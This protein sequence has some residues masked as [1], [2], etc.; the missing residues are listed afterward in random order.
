MLDDEDAPIHPLFAGAPSST[1]F[2]KLR[3]RIVRAVRV[4]LEWPVH[5]QRLFWA[6]FFAT[7]GLIQY[8]YMAIFG[9]PGW[10]PHWAARWLDLLPLVD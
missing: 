7:L 10:V 2:K 5:K 3:K 1:E 9:I 4:Y 8:T 6:G